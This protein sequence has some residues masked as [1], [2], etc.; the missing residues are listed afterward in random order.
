M[1][2]QKIEKQ[3]NYLTSNINLVACAHDM[4]VFDTDSGKSIGKI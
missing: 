1:H 3:I 4:D 2:K